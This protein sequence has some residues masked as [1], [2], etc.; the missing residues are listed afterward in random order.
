MAGALLQSPQ[1]GYYMRYSVQASCGCHTGKIRRN[2]EDNFYFNGYSL[3]RIHNGLPYP[4]C[5]E[6]NPGSGFLVSVFDGMGGEC[7]GEYASFAA[8]QQMQH[9]ND[10][11]NGYCFSSKSHLFTMINQLND[12]VLKAQQE[13]C[14]E[15]MG[16]TMVSFYFTGRHV[17]SCN[18]GD[19]RSF[20]L[21]DNVLSQLSV[22][23][24]VTYPDK[25][26]K[27]APLTQYLGIN[28]EELQIEP[29]IVKGRYKSGDVFLLCSDGLTDM[30][31]DQEIRDIMLNHAE[32]KDCVEALI[33]AALDH[34]GRDNI[35]VVICKV[36][37]GKYV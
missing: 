17:Y 7:F 13:M 9:D 21:R 8:A 19:S 29:H 26:R 23:H 2:N 32:P 5:A 18:L 34:G 6:S 15:H 11:L 28:T 12:A 3:D 36:A 31:T 10:T 20:L 33:Q 27:K 16:S 1:R 30:L 4:I 35:T 25:S 14:T 22:D 24:V 37:E